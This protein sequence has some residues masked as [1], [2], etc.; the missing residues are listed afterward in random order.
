MKY[1][2]TLEQDPE[3]ITITKIVYYERNDLMENK[4]IKISKVWT[5]ANKYNDNVKLIDVYDNVGF[6]FYIFCRMNETSFSRAKGD[7]DSKVNI[8]EFL[9]MFGFLDY[10]TRAKKRTELLTAIQMMQEDS[11]ITFY[12]DLSFVDEARFDVKVKDNQSLYCNVEKFEVDKFPDCRFIRITRHEFVNI[13]K[14]KSKRL[15]LLMHYVSIMH[16]ENNG[17]KLCY[18]SFKGLHKITGYA[19]NT[20]TT[21]NELLVELCVLYYDNAGAIYDTRDKMHKQKSNTYGRWVNKDLVDDKIAEIR[22]KNESRIYNDSGEK[23]KNRNERV[24]LKHKA[25]NTDDEVAKAEF[26]AKR[27]ELKYINNKMEDINYL[28]MH[29]KE[30]QNAIIKAKLAE[31]KPVAVES[32]QTPEQVDDE[33]VEDVVASDDEPWGST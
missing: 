8:G 15:E 29:P 18:P 17:D 14:A 20:C 9:D 2:I 6:A 25:N 22:L 26:L 31:D 10:K 1:I 32:I 5:E 4:F 28:H 13:M 30:S 21:Y 27:E 7:Y 19:Q 12:A 3:H 33:V 24:S 23:Q 11:I 16:Y